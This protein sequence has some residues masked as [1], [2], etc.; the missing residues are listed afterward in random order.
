MKTVGDK[1]IVKIEKKEEKTE[2][3]IILPDNFDRSN[4]TDSREAFGEVVAVG[5]GTKREPMTVK[6]GDRVIFDFYDGESIDDTDTYRSLSI[7]DIWGTV[8][9]GEKKLGDD[10]E[11]F[12]Y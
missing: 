3:G 2:G 12:G 11:D 7:R 1:L 6:V 8:P 5:P 4:F 10:P 9:N